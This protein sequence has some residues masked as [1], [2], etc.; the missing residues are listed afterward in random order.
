MRPLST[1]QLDVD[2]SI[3][4]ALYELLLHHGYI[5]DRSIH[6]NP[7][8]Y[9]AAM[10]DIRQSKGFA[11]E[12]F[13][14]GA[15]EDRENLEI[16]RIVITGQGFIPGSAGQDFGASYVKNLDNVNFTKYAQ[17]TP[18]SNYRLRIELWSNKTAQDRLLEA[19]RAAAIPNLAFINKWDDP[20]QQ[21]L[22][23]YGFNA[24][25]P[26]LQHGLTHKIY[27]YEAV[28]VAEVELNEVATN[29]VPMKEITVINNGI[30]DDSIDTNLNNEIVKVQ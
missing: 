19:I 7:T 25:V 16:P 29:I 22:L 4:K 28:D 24:S 18:L 2:R 20:T 27:N 23:V 10:A 12:L 6:T 13:G 5:A 1:V 9:A 11:V 8:N 17:G 14:N 15:P 30:N 26:E 21:Y 3:E